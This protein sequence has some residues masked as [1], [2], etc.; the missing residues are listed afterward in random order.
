M[1]YQLLVEEMVKV[2]LQHHSFSVNSEK[3]RV[4]IDSLAVK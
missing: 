1:H 3:N 2:G 4:F